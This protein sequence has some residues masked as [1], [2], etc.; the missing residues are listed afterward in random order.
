MLLYVSEKMVENEPYLTEI[1]LKIGDG[2][3]GTGMK[4]GFSHVLKDLAPY[5]PT[6]C[7]DVLRMTGTTLLDTMGGASGVLFGTVF[8]SGLTKR[9][10]KQEFR[11]QD[12]AE[13]FSQSLKVLKQRGKAKVGDKTMVDAFEPAVA[14]LIDAVKKN[15]DLESGFSIEKFIYGGTNKVI[16]TREDISGK[17]INVN[18]VL[19]HLGI[20]NIASGFDYQNDHAKLH[21]FLE[22]IGCPSLLEPVEGNLR[23]NVK[24]FDVSSSVMSEIN[25]PGASTQALCSAPTSPLTA[26]AFRSC[27][28]KNE[29][30]VCEFV[31]PCFYI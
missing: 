2:D 25:H 24:I 9:E 28:R 17:G 26:L 21:G 31:C 10:P 13:I 12:F 16:S 8:I 23:V 19:Q 30:G 11:L 29:S 18:L 1:D 3:H 22:K 4:L 15:L 7:D 5:G 14:G 6:S 27:S 20:P